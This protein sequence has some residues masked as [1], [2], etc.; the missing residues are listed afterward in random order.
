MEIPSVPSFP[1]QHISTPNNPVQTTPTAT[2][3]SSSNYQSSSNPSNQISNQTTI[4][5]TT[6]SEKKK[7]TKQK[8]ITSSLDQSNCIQEH[9][10]RVPRQSTISSFTERYFLIYLTLIK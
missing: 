3:T 10:K 1:S 9:T 8:S 5:S 7:T 2:L 4:P 6:Q